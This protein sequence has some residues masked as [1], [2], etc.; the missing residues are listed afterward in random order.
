MLRWGRLLIDMAQVLCFYAQR[1]GTLSNKGFG[2][3]D[4]AL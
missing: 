4:Y 2:Q 3:I 1:D